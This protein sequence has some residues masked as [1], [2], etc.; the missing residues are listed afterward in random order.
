[1]HNQSNPI[2]FSI[3]ARAVEVGQEYQ[4][5]GVSNGAWYD[6]MVLSARWNTV[7]KSNFKYKKE[8]KARHS[9]YHFVL[10]VSQCWQAA[11]LQTGNA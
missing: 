4:K 5:L 8:R 7:L 9:M 11:F 10:T 1:M 2:V 6:V 3:A